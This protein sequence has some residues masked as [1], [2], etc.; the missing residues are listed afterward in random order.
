[1]SQFDFLAPKGHEDWLGGFAV[2]AGDNPDLLAAF[3]RD[4][5]DYGSIMFKALSDRVAEAAAEWLHEQVRKEHWG[6]APDEQF[7]N[8][9]LID[10]AY[11]GIRPAPGYPSQPDHTEKVLLFRLLDAPAN[12]GVS[13]TNSLAMSPASSVSGLYLSHPDSHYFAVGR[14][15][16]DQVE[17]Y[18]RR[19]GWT[20]EEAERS[21]AP[22]LD[23]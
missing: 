15:L 2:T 18:A 4:R 12:A 13:L 10:E 5:D 14:I 9:E 16:P 17:D 21:L 20:V 6:Y 3:E 11:D 1:M 7:S 8:K 19:K 22:I 23:A